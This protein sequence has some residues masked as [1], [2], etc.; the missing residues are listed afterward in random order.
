MAIKPWLAGFRARLQATRRRSVLRR[1]AQR[2]LM[3]VQ[4]LEQRTLL[5][6]T[7]LLVG[8]E[9]TI[10]T[11]ANESVSVSADASGNVDVQVNSQPLTG[12][13]TIAASALTSLSVFTGDGDNVIDLS[14]VSASS[15]SALTTIVVNAGDGHDSITG[16]PDLAD[17]IAGDDGNDTL[18]GQGGDDTLDGGNGD[19]SIVGGAGIDSIIG[20]DGDDAIDGGA[21]GDTIASGD[22]ADTIIAG[23]GNDTVDSGDGND[24]IDGGAGDDFLNSMSGVDTV[25]GDDGSDTVFAGAGDD[26]V[27]GG[28][29]NDSLRGQSGRDSV[30]GGAGDDFVSGEEDEDTLSGGDG[31]DVVNGMQ[32]NDVVDGGA[33]ADRVYGGSGQDQVLGG[34]GNDTLK[35]NS[36]NDTLFGGS[37]ADCIHGDSGND[38]IFGAS[39]EVS[40]TAAVTVPAEGDTGTSTV[41]F[42]VTRN[43]FASGTGSV[44]F[45]TVDG[46]AIAGQDYTATS[47]T[48]TFA[49][50]ETS[51]TVSIPVIADNLVEGNETFSVVL[52]NPSNLAI[53]VGTGIATIVDDDVA[54]ISIGDVTVDPEGPPGSTTTAA[55]SVTLSNP[56]VVP[57]TVN[58]ATADGTATAGSD[59]VAA[60]GTVTFPANSTVAQTIN[61]TVNGDATTESDET[62]DVVLSGATNGTIIDGTGTVT[63]ADDD[64]GSFSIDSQTFS[65]VTQTDLIFSIDISGSATIAFPGATVGDVNSDGQAN[66]VIDVELASLINYVNNTLATDFPAARVAI[67]TFFSNS[68][69]VRSVEMSPTAG[70]VPVANNLSTTAAADV[71]NN[72]VNDIEE[73]LRSIQ[74]RSLQGGTGDIVGNGNQ[75]FSTLGTPNGEG[76]LVVISD[77][78]IGNATAASVTTAMQDG[79]TVRAFEVSAF[80]SGNG[81]SATALT[82]DPNAV[83]VLTPQ[84]LDLELNQLVGQPFTVT[85]SQPLAQTVTVD[86]ATMDGT[87]T[88]GQDYVA[89]NGTLTFAPGVT[90]QEINIQVLDDSVVESQEAFTVVLSNPTGGAMIGTGTGTGTINDDDGGSIVAFSQDDLSAAKL[91]VTQANLI[92]VPQA[93]LNGTASGPEDDTIFGDS[94]NDTIIASSGNDSINGGSGNDS[95]DAAA[96]NDSVLGGAGMDTIAGG[97]GNDTLNGQGGDDSVDGGDGEDELVFEGTGNGDDTVIGG[98]GGDRAVLNTGATD[99]TVVIGQDADGRITLTE[100]GSRVAIDSTISTVEVNTQAGTDM[101]TIGDLSNVPLSILTVDAGIGNDTIDASGMFVGQVRVEL[102][103]GDGNDTITGSGQGDNLFGD[104]GD[105]SINSGAGNDSVQGGTGND[106][107]NAGD[108]DD[109]VSGGDD[110]DT[111]NGDAGDDSLSGDVGDDALVGGVGNDTL[112]G[113]FGADNLNGNSGDDSLDGGFGRDRISAGAGND[114]ADG[115]RD[116]DVI[117][118]Q[119]GNDT[120]LGDHGDDTLNGNAGDDEILGGDGNDN[121]MGGAGRDGLVGNDGDDLIQGQGGA[122]TILGNDGN[123]TL[124]GGGSNDTILGG[125]GDDTLDGDSGTDVGATGEGADNTVEIETINEAFMLTPFQLTQLD[126]I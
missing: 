110:N 76:L 89:Q 60:S 47:G 21:D 100:G 22:G 56:S 124:R 12:F 115:G 126:G 11:D 77:F 39:A 90:T 32:D 6:A 35:G 125:Q 23:T 94:G 112:R 20:D 74:A 116:D 73:I 33:G 108:G 78:F 1:P 43:S 45:A 83:E 114:R 80:Q 2:Q 65:E 13:G 66:T 18:T 37:G 96:G 29:G 119:A 42:T 31:D 123:D 68:S 53:G 49:A 93:P 16:S 51:Q 52:S 111:I 17:N 72:N 54:A 36:G 3:D 41:L 48:I 70:Y 75:V 64:G 30:N 44:D 120:I 59:Y 5:A 102:R 85:L 113:S 117:N 98:N 95:I 25:N 122:D 87:A 19:D 97:A 38:L 24:S 8:S 103:G 106:I 81:P 91:A 84:D 71:N 15:F 10:L 121:I 34:D 82:F 27:S 104:A 62:F 107:I 58:F 61:V 46:S 118:G 67:T 92:L 105:D 26:I 79:R 109:S 40:I 88:A 28:A 57:V 86:Y 101:I 63:I 50:G 9:L 14:G 99:D 69:S 55:L 7:G 4:N